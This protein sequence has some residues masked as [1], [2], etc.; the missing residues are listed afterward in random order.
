MISIKKT[1]VSVLV[2]LP[3]VSSAVELTDREKEIV[4]SYEPKLT[5]SELDKFTYDMD[6]RTKPGD[7][8]YTIYNQPTLPEE[9]RYLEGPRDRVRFGYLKQGRLEKIQ[10]ALK[11]KDEKDKQLLELQCLSNYLDFFRKDITNK[12]MIPKKV[13]DP[14]TDVEKDEF[15]PKI[16]SMGSVSDGSKKSYTLELVEINSPFVCGSFS[17]LKSDF[18]LYHEYWG[19]CSGKLIDI[20]VTRDYCSITDMD[21]NAGLKYT[22]DNSIDPA[23]FKIET[24]GTPE[25]VKTFSEKIHINTDSNQKLLLND[26]NRTY[27]GMRTKYSGVNIVRR[28]MVM[29][30]SLDE[31]DQLI[32]SISDD[33]K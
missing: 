11:F 12:F 27:L 15:S 6:S 25:Q 10:L 19:Y 22:I 3:L 20:I 33:S 14:F 23:K 26:T 30:Q 4:K 31:K 7:Y 8:G 24:Q 16:I 17:D 13:I 2:T 1:L 29:Y 32:I 21:S 28:E 9:K 5:N 18:S